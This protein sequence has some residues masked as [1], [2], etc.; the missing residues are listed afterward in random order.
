MP[1]R[2]RPVLAVA[3]SS[4]GTSPGSGAAVGDA[5]GVGVGVAAPGIAIAYTFDFLPSLPTSSDSSSRLTVIDSG[6]GSLG[7][8]ALAD[9]PVLVGVDDL[10]RAGG[11]QRDLLAPGEE[12][13]VGDHRRGVADPAQLV[14]AV[15]ARRR[16]G[17][18]RPRPQRPW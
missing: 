15:A 5:V 11:Q 12:G 2:L 3:G 7:R 18:R 8:S 14:D 17:R 16:T 4:S 13:A 1:A 6:C 10:D 9:L